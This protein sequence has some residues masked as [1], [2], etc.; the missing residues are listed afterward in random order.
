[1]YIC[2]VCQQALTESTQEISNA[3]KAPKTLRCDQGHSF[4]RHKKGYVNLLLAQNK[5]S[6]QPGDDVDMVAGRRAFLNAGYY[7]ILAN[8]IAELMAAHGVKRVLD[9]G[10]GEGYYLKQ[11]LDHQPDMEAYGFDISKPAIQLA[12]HYKA[13]EWAVASSARMPYSDACFDAVL[14]VFS[15]VESDEFLRVLKPKGLVLFAGPGAEHLMSL[16]QVIYSDIREYETDKHQTYFSEQFTLLDTV[17][18]K[19]PF[20]LDSQ[21]QI[22]NLLS[23]TPHSQRMTREA[24]ERLGK[25][26]R[27]HDSADFRLYL[28]QKN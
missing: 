16:R 8:N 19:V 5:R 20:L 1:M 11:M 12:S 4:D 2:P 26:E 15:R 22:Q 6:K 17:E 14:S 7:Q 3:P 13:I 27:L 9:A 28:Y 10:C 18:L 21:D 24:T 23:M 25:V